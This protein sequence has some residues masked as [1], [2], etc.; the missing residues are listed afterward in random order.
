MA[1]EEWK[2]V[3]RIDF[4]DKKKPDLM[5]KFV[6]Q[7]AKELLSAASLIMDKR[8]PDIAVEHGDM[9]AGRKQIEL[10]KDDEPVEEAHECSNASGGA[11]CDVCFGEI[12]PAL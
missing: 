4:D 10:F 5:T 11:R 6:M 3:L 7:N 1:L 8:K 2:I 9:F 12:T